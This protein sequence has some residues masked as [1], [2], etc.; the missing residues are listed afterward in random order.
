MKLPRPTIDL[1]TSLQE[2]DVWVTPSLGEI[3]DTERY[4]QELAQL[5]DGF[6][7]LRQATQDFVDEQAC[8]PEK[9]VPALQRVVD[10]LPPVRSTELLNTIASALYLVTG[11]TDNNV[12]CQFPLYL[13]DHA[14]LTTLPIARKQGMSSIPLPRV[15]KAQRLM[16]IVAGLRDYPE[17]QIALLQRF[18]EFIISDESYISQLW[19][20][21]HS[22]VAL[23][24]I[25]KGA[26]L[27]SPLAT[28]KVR[29]SVMAR[30][31]HDPEKI[32]RERLTEWGLQAG[33]DF[34]EADVTPDQVLGRSPDSTRTRR[35]TRAYDF[36]LPYRSWQEGSR[37]LIQSQFYA[38]DSGSVS[39]KNVDQT[40]STRDAT[41]EIIPD[42]VFV[43]YVDGAG[44]FASLH[45]DLRSLLAMPDTTSFFQIRTAP[46]RLR[47]ELQAIGFLTPL[48]IEHA[49]LRV[50]Q[51][52]R[53][54][55]GVLVQEGYSE[56]EIDRCLSQALQQA[57]ILQP[58]AEMMDIQPDRRPR[59]RRYALLDMA[60]IHGQ[61]LAANDIPG[62]LLIPG[63]GPFYGLRQNDLIR[64]A[65]QEVPGLAQD[66]RH[67]EA[68]FDDLQW[69]V[70]QR[71]ITS[72]V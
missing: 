58:G 33:T 29:G 26:D 3:R 5:V 48:E 19:A 43:E 30:G 69:L 31:G 66:W 68:A 10:K 2:F 17:H 38:G 37:L 23:S 52:Q 49:I 13:R 60:A 20:I 4:Q 50:G 22:Y 7:V 47:R 71:F 25:G 14:R 54:V 41:K 62:K 15:L 24:S 9:F 55:Y 35:K 18:I 28:F 21:G 53:Q 12:K 16:R 27:L 45:G 32:L 57:L 34:N 44:Y 63:Y 11:K 46:V 36:V 51:E 70:D 61:S 8:Q 59:C 39:H 67:A 72:G 42:A 1:A 56:D 64:L 40:R 65:I 6:D